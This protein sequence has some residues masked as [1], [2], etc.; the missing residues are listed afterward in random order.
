[1]IKRIEVI[2]SDNEIIKDIFPDFL[3]VTDLSLYS[4]IDLLIIDKSLSDEAI[5]KITK[6]S[7]R[8]INLTDDLALE[9]AV[10]LPKPFRLHKLLEMVDNYRK[11]ASIFCLINDAIL[12]SQRSG[13][14]F[15]FDKRI[16]LNDKEN[17]LFSALLMA[18]NYVVLKEDLLSLVWGYAKDAETSTLDTHLARLRA[19]FPAG[20]INNKD[21]SISLSVKWIR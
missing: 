5:K 6:I 13:Y 3:I 9:N 21:G 1:M 2:F 8:I 14:V 4:K 15:H 20:F 17:E 19:Y 16:K 11:N 18:P 10:I 7:D 12:Y